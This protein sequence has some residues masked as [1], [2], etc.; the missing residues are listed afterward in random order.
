[1]LVREHGGSRSRFIWRTSYL[2]I[3]GGFPEMLT[4]YVYNKAENNFRTSGVNHAL[5]WGK[6]GLLMGE[7]LPAKRVH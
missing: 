7:F 4:D 6:N 5:P 1:M 3:Y 2:P